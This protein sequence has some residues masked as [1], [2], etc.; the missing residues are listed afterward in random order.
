MEHKKFMNIQRIKPDI[1]SGFEVGDKIVIQ[2]K[3]DGA[4]AAIRYDAETD[5]IVAQSRKHIL[6]TSNNLR[7]FYE[8]SQSLD[9]ELVASG[10]GDD[11]VLF[12]EW[13]VPHTV[14]YPDEKYNQF[15]VYDAY[16]T[17]SEEYLPQ[18]T[19]E[20]IADVLNL[21]YIPVFYRGEF[22]SWE[23]CYSFVGKTEM[24][25]EYGEG[26]FN[27]RTKILMADG[28]EKYITE[29]KK[30]DLVKS[31]NIVTKQIENKKVTNIFN[32]GKKNIDQWYNLAVFPKGTSSKNNIS[33]IFCATKNHKFYCGNGQYSEIINCNNVYHYGKIFDKIRKQAFLGLMVSDMHYS[34]GIFSISQSSEKSEDFYNLF[35]EFLSGESRLVSGKGS[36]IDVQHFRKQETTIFKKD[37]IVNNKINYIKVF[38]DLNLIG[39]SFFFMGDGYGG[40][41]GEMK[42]CLA[43][44]TEEECK[45]ILS[46]FNNYFNTNAKLSFDNRVTNGSGGE[47][48][49]SN[50]EG[51]RIMK[52][53]SKYIMPKYRYKINAIEDADDF[54][55]IPNI[56]FGLTKRKLYSKKELSKLK[57][58]I[59]HKTITAY[60]IEVEDNHNYFANG[61]L[62]HNC[63][64]KNQTKLNNP[65]TRNPFYIKIV[66]D[67]FTEVHSSSKKPVSAEVLKAKEEEQA[68]VGT[69]VTEARV[70]KILHKLVDEGI[71]PENWGADEMPIVAKN[72]PRAVFEDCLKEEPDVVAKVSIF[73]KVANSI[74]MKIARDMI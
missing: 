20:A 22:Q 62:V 11:I 56:E 70:R 51:R 74:A 31:Y 43:S 2:E 13:L 41:R 10:L 58:W 34:K 48:R 7:G 32:N 64:I 60:D 18:C 46:Y 68:I 69:V 30:G 25:G 50:S 1:V 45:A 16:N 71:L 54:I 27:S 52:M 24:G 49:T 55:G 40:K 38:N 14:K 53:M 3:I 39:W 21:N 42:L 17:K 37:F 28:T 5:S 72:L 23:H 63:V 35:K 36:F 44:Y 66:G 67:K 29:V 33:G 65:N 47:I 61:C 12:G 8:W 4:N 15:Y 9:K 6:N 57:T 26:C 19:V 73:G 59:G